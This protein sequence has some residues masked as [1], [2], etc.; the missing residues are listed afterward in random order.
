MTEIIQTP[1]IDPRRSKFV[2][3]QFNLRTL[4]LFFLFC[5]CLCSWFAVKL[6][7]AQQQRVTVEALIKLGARVF[8][9][10]EDMLHGG[11]FDGPLPGPAWLRNQ[12]GIDF[13]SRATGVRCQDTFKAKDLIRL[14]ELPNLFCLDLCQTT[15]SNKEL[16]SVNEIKSLKRIVLPASDDNKTLAHISGLTNL[17]YLFLS[18]HYYTDEEMSPIAGMINLRDLSLANTFITDRGLVILKDM[19]KLNSIG[20]NQTQIDG[21][22]LVH[23][24]KLKRLEDLSLWST[25]LTDQGLIHLENIT[26]L[27]YLALNDTKITDKGLMHLRLLINLERLELSETKVGDAGLVFL[28]NH[29][30]LKGLGLSDTLITDDGLIHLRKLHQLE[31]LCIDNVKITESGV[32]QL[33]KWLPNCDIQYS[34]LPPNKSSNA[35]QWAP[36]PFPRQ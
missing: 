13:F 8:Y 17:E 16:E 6:Q 4:L 25:Q 22:G 10:Y 33:K 5:A 7:Q 27:K 9:D 26:T 11:E 20:L 12:L 30:N 3:Y 18:G 1:D 24:A 34:P 2:W 21:S 19:T 36:A 32:R 15:F 28:E 29:T 35:Q 31:S 23:I 14:K